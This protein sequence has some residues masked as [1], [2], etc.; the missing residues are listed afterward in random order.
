[1]RII[2][3]PGGESSPPDE[4]WLAELDAALSG[5][6]EGSAADSWRELRENVRSLAVPASAEFLEQLEREFASPQRDSAQPSRRRA[7]L[8]VLGRPSRPAPL[9]WWRRWW[10]WRR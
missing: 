2:A 9:R 4:T 6:R 1:M 3:F 7:W 5:E 10:W 8:R